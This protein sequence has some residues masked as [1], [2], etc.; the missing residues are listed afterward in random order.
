MASVFAICIYVF[1]RLVSVHSFVVVF[2]VVLVFICRNGRRHEHVLALCAV[3]TFLLL[4][5]LFCL[6]VLFY[7]CVWTDFVHLT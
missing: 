3:F 1:F 5:I 4:Y 6:Y 2:V 7:I